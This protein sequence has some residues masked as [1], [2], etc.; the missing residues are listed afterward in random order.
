MLF[1]GVTEQKI[2]FEQIPLILDYLRIYYIQNSDL[3]LNNPAIFNIE[4]LKHEG[5]LKELQNNHIFLKLIDNETLIIMQALKI[6][7]GIITL[8]SYYAMVI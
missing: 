6:N 3:F 5:K 8:L 7:N 4:D 2:Q 1:T